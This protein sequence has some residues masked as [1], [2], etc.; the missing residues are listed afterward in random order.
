MA[1]S[2]SEDSVNEN[3]GALP[4]DDVIIEDVETNTTTN[5]TSRLL[6]NNQ[7]THAIN[8][9]SLHF[10]QNHGVHA[11]VVLFFVILGAVVVSLLDEK[12]G[13]LE[14]QAKSLQEQIKTML[15]DFTNLQRNLSD[16]QNSLQIAR[17]LADLRTVNE[18]I[19]VFME[20]YPSISEYGSQLNNTEVILNQTIASQE[21]LENLVFS[22]NIT[23]SK[24]IQVVNESCNTMSYKLDELTSTFEN[25]NATL[26]LIQEKL[27][28][29]TDE[30]YIDMNSFQQNL[31]ALNQD[32]GRTVESL[33][34]SLAQ[35]NGTANQA[36][37]YS[38][39]FGGIF[40]LECGEPWDFKNPMTGTYSCPPWASEQFEV[41]EFQASDKASPRTCTG[42]LYVCVSYGITTH[43]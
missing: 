3:D 18:S 9:C 40:S 41:G 28:N 37:A 7:H 35:V 26:G 19:N 4:T 23:L 8:C 29:V 20:R 2:G 15:Q 11:M 24:N 43:G 33:L 1:D 36:R 22:I 32:F 30:Y 10:W 27:G 39:R 6:E 13:K 38:N 34:G 5:E 31:T 42:V 21:S 17:L 14:E 25:I 12:T 16:L